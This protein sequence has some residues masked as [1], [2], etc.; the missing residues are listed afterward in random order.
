[1]KLR[2]VFAAIGFSAMLP[3]HAGVIGLDVMNTSEDAAVLLSNALVGSG[4]SIV[5]GSQVFQGLL[6]DDATGQSALFDSASFTDGSHSVNIGGGAFLT[7]GRANLAGSNTAENF[8]ATT[9]SGSDTDLNA[10]LAVNGAPSTNT[11]DVNFI[12]FDFTVAG[13][14]NAITLD[15][16]FGSEE[17]PDQSVTD[18]LG[19]F[20]DGVNFAFFPDNSLVSF[21]TGVN[22]GN[23]NNNTGNTFDLEYDGFS[24]LLN[25]V[26]LLDMSLTTHTI[27]IAIADTAD[28]IYDS[29][30]WL[31]NMRATNADNGGVNN[32]PSSVPA[33]GTLALV[34][35]GL[36]AA[37]RRKKQH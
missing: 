17:F 37:L 20:V 28:S 12:E 33:P 16:I 9:N 2:N 34:G 11:N 32:P 30:V 6:G 15:F 31:S 24:N 23:F 13:S 14:F 35:L 26:G 25:V 27:K 3:V 7:T 19:I 5:D 4:V 10:L 21:V 29:G 8:G 36:F 22:A 18:V 1:M